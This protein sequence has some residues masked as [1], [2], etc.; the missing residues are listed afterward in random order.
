MKC[1]KC[2]NKAVIRLRAHRIALCREDFLSFVLNRVQQTIKQ[3]KLFVP[4]EKIVV[5]VSGGKD[6]LALFDILQRLG[7]PVE[8]FHIDLGIDTTRERYQFCE[9][10][11]QYKGLPLPMRRS[12]ASKG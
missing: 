12:E 6:S 1:K 2:G 3:Y 10:M 7:Y 9:V 4:K 5:A 8:G 11:E